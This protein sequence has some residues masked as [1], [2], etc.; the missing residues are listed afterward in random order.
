MKPQRDSLIVEGKN[1]SHTLPYATFKKTALPSDDWVY[2][3][4]YSLRSDHIQIKKE[5]VAIGKLKTI[6]QA[7]FKLSSKLGFQTM[8][9]RDLSRETGI[10][11]GG[12]YSYIGSKEELANLIEAVLRSIVADLLLA[13]IDRIEG[14]DAKLYTLISNHIFFSELLHPWFYFVFMESKNLSRKQKEEA[15]QAE[16]EFEGTV[17]SFIEQGQREGVFRE[18]DAQL[19]ASCIMTLVQDWHLKRWK[20]RSRKVSPDGYRKFVLGMVKRQLLMEN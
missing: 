7:T 3:K 11:M 9:L 19:M 5:G 10:S 4:V 17:R 18:I 1:W 14:V 2:R 6:L 20:H 8:S 12:L 16:L 15:K 13:D